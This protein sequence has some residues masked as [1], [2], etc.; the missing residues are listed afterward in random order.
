MAGEQE[1]TYV[2]VDI[3][4][5]TQRLEH[6]K[7]PNG[8][9]YKI[10]LSLDEQESVVKALSALNDN[11]NTLNEEVE[12]N[13]QVVAASLNDLNSRI[14]SLVQENVQLRSEIASLKDEIALIKKEYMAYYSV[15][16]SKGIGENNT[17]EVVSGN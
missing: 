7:L 11:F 15:D 4:D 14:V 10:G 13:E 2:N 16:A 8:V 3:S 5:E 9:T 1:V 17:Y 6:L 12:D